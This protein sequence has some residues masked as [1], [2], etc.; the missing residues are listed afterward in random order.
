LALKLAREPASW[1]ARLAESRETRPLFDTD[2][3]RRN[4][5]AAYLQMWERLS[6]PPRGFRLEAA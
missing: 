5:E 4:L 2:R 1:R 3:F 6:G